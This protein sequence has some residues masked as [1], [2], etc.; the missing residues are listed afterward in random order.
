MQVRDADGLDFF[1]GGFAVGAG[2]RVRLEELATAFDGAGGREEEDE[3]TAFAD[4]PEVCS[5]AVGGFGFF[6]G[7][8]SAVERSTTSR[9]CPSTRCM[10][11][12]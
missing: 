2:E 6:L 3:A 10:C 12:R 5:G 11:P 9:G 7:G 1:C 8:R 4:G